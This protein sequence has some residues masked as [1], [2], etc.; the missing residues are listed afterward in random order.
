MKLIYDCIHGYI[1]H[2]S[3]AIKIIDTP[4]FQRLRNIKQLGLASYVFPTG[5]LILVL[6]IHLEYHIFQNNL[7]PIL[8]II[9]RNLKL[10]IMILIL[11]LFLDLFMI[12]DML[13]PHTL[14]QVLIP[15]LGIKGPLTKHENRSIWFITTHC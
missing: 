13:Q 4:I 5:S 8:N 1:Q 11:S 15:A 12:L 14:R 7:L 6:N 2:S 3:T 9:N 10:L